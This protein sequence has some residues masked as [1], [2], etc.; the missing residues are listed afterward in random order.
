[1]KIDRIRVGAYGPLADL[2]LEGLAED[3]LIVV[4]GPNEAG[5]SSLRSFVASMLYGFSP[6]AREDHPATPLDGHAHGELELALPGGTRV[7]VERHLRARPTARAWRGE[8][9]EELAN[10]PLSEVAWLE[11]GTYMALHAFDADELRG[12]DAA[13]WREIE[14][15]LLGGASPA[16]LRPAAVA[17]QELS[18]ARMRCGGRSPRQAAL[19]RAVGAALGAARGAARGACGRPGARRGGRRARARARRAGASPSRRGAARGPP[20]PARSPRARSARLAGARAPAREAEQLVPEPLAARVGA[21]PGE[22]LEGLRGELEERA[23]ELADCARSSTRRGLAS[24]LG[25]RERVLIEHAATI[26]EAALARA[27]DEG[28]RDQLGIE[29]AR[30]ESQAARSE[31]L[32]Q[33]VLGHPLREADEAALE[34]VQI[35]DLQAAAARCE[36]ST[37][38]PARGCARAGRRR[39]QR[40]SR[41]AACSPCSRS[42]SPGPPAAGRR[43]GARRRA[44]RA[45]ARKRRAA[46]TMRAALAERSAGGSDARGLAR[47]AARRRVAHRASRSDARQRHR[48]AARVTREHALSSRRLAQLEEAELRAAERGATL[49]AVLGT[50]D[51][52]RLSGELEAAQRRDA[53]ATASRASGSP[54]W[55]RAGRG[56]RPARDAVASV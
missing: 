34:T 20:R 54:S 44:R 31:E 26:R 22:R 4:Y 16:F 6:A 7:R 1:M 46:R 29:R 23:R 48:A 37:P 15:R 50:D 35:A 24:Q 14:Q 38:A 30:A 52:E 18:S 32:A 56:G 47:R 3:D 11:R 13:T 41:C 10:R 39:S 33:R 27:R 42:P 40:Q 12:L 21:Q 17:A 51:P 8:A 53:Q 25:E 9:Q 55:S 36:R 2:E 28:E 19:G 45:R 5:K 43:R 49:A